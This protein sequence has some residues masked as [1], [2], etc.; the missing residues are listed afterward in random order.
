MAMVLTQE[1][2]PEEGGQKKLKKLTFT[3]KKNMPELTGA[4]IKLTRMYLANRD[5]SFVDCHLEVV[6][7]RLLLIVVHNV[8]EHHASATISD[9]ISDD[10]NRPCM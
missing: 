9:A 6:E 7:C 5:R 1:E 10:Y 4:V 3:V 2:I 8:I